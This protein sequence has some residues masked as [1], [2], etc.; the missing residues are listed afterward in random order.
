ETF[1]AKY[2]DKWAKP[3]PNLEEFLTRFSKWVPSDGRVLDSGTGTG[4]DLLQFLEQGFDAV[5]IDYSKT[6]LELTK[7]RRGK[8]VEGRLRLMD[9]RDL[10]FPDNSFQ[11]IWDNA[12]FL[13][14]PSAQVDQ[15]IQQYHR[16]LAPDGILFIRVKELKADEKPEALVGEEGEER[17]Y[18]F[19]TKEELGY[20]LER[21]GFEILDIDVKSEHGTGKTGNWVYAFAR[22]PKQA[23]ISITD[24]DQEAQIIRQDVQMIFA[25]EF[26]HVLLEESIGGSAGEGHSAVNGVV[27]PDGRI[28]KFANYQDLPPDLRDRLDRGELYEF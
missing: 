12:T 17:F 3:D 11:G 27:D 21:N 14:I 20:L 18:K 7:T 28:L 19:Y 5:G 1:S 10:K 4:R 26:N 16:V 24:T 22:K 2:W 25:R 13:H 6:M 15:V 23:L 8:I 9:M